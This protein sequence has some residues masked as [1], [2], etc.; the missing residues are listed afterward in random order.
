MAENFA[1]QAGSGQINLFEVFSNY[2]QDQLD[3][4]SDCI[5]LNYSHRQVWSECSIW[6]PQILR[7]QKEETQ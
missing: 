6:Q 5:E 3:V 4:A 2:R 7:S 1:A